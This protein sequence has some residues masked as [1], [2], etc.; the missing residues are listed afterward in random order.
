MKIVMLYHRR[1]RFDKMAE[2]GAIA[3]TAVK[4]GIYSGR[5]SGSN[6]IIGA[7]IDSTSKELAT[8]ST[9]RQAATKKCGACLEITNYKIQITN[10]RGVLQI[11]FIKAKNNCGDFWEPGMLLTEC[12]QGGRMVICCYKNKKIED[13]STEGTESF[14][15]N[16]LT[17]KKQQETAIGN[18]HPAVDGDRSVCEIHHS[19]VGSH[20]TVVGSDRS[21][22][23]SH[24][25]VVGSDHLMVGSHHTVVGSDRSMVGSHHTV[26]GSDHSM[27][28]SHHAVVGSDHLMV[29]SH[30]TIVGSDHLMVGSH[31]TI[32]GS[33]HSIVGSHHTV[34]GNDR[35]MVGSRHT[36]I[37]FT[38]QKNI[39]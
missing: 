13:S 22:I 12:F 7:I 30:H 5:R 9:S 4:N 16:L 2:K 10:K 34:V 35:S 3:P 14:P 33:D 18:R 36:A 29:G 20:H 1:I 6:E 11:Y 17:N 26:V 8:E 32:V 39:T 21:M 15:L 19:M 24:H 38:I 25:T 28:G 27:V 37:G 23:G 31:H